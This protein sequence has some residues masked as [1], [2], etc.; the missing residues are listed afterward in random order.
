MSAR[1]L[2]GKAL[3][4]TIRDEIKS[5]VMLLKEK[6]GIV[7]GLAAILAGDNPASRIYVSKKA[8]ACDQ[9]GLHSETLTLPA[10]TNQV[11]LLDHIHRLNSDSR[12]HGILVQLPLPD[13]INENELLL[14]VSPE[15]DVDGFH[16][17]NVG[18]MVIGKEKSFLPCTPL[19]IQ[20]LLVRNG[21]ETSGKHVVVIGRSN[22]VGKPMAIMMMQKAAGADATVTVCH[23]RTRN[24]AD[25]IRLG[26]IVIAA[27]GKAQFVKAD[28]IKPGA[29]VIDVGMNR[30]PDATKKS[31]TRLCGDV[32]YDAVKE[33]A[34]AITPVPGGV[35]PMTIAMLLSNTL[36]SAK[37]SL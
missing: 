11:E 28:M 18:R 3:S 35:G 34:G 12:I 5:E 29:V 2:D 25:V 33:V 31:G 26:D 27:M 36:K 19:G 24:I 16:P 9:A 23:S 20:T 15:K 7:P 21:V 37:N 4:E 6:H 8:E 10:S 22:I 14:S 32:D 1:I 17:V 13:H 30:I